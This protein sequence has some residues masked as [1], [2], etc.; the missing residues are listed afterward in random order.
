MGKKANWMLAIA[1]I[2]LSSVSFTAR[3]RDLKSQF[4]EFR[5]GVWLLADGNYAVYTDTHYFV[6]FAGGDS[7]E[8]NIYCG[9]S[10]IRF[11]EKGM[12]R[13]QII[14]VRQMPGS[15]LNFYKESLF[16]PD[17]TEKPLEFDPTLFSPGICNIKDG[18]IYDSITEVTDKYIL[19]SS[20]NGD[21]EKIFS[22]GVSVYLPASG[23]EAYSYRIEQF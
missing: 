6:I 10:Q 23:G 18:V 7:K 19:L 16:R 13:K 3:G 20:C 5:K 11:H 14:R 17:K 4:A 22:N 12:A 15:E 1:A 21:K 9:A 2:V 8:P